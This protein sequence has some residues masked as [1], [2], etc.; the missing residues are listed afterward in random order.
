MVHKITE[1]GQVGDEDP[2]ARVGKKGIV[3]EI[4]CGAMV[5]VETATAIIGWLQ[6]QI[7]L[8]EKLRATAAQSKEVK[9][10]R[11]Q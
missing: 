9:N 4:E 2:E 7:S 1:T 11:V 6:T 8:V 3:R 10:D 5:S